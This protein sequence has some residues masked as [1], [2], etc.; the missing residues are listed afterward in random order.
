MLGQT[1]IFVAEGMGFCRGQTADQTVIQP[2]QNQGKQFQTVLYTCDAIKNK[3]IIL[4]SCSMQQSNK[5]KKKKSL[6][7]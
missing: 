1:G 6:N 5:K 4:K 7:K 3:P 2:R